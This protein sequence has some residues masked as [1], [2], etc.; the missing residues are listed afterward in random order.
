MVTRFVN[1][2]GEVLRVSP[3][4]PLPVVVQGGGPT[5]V[6]SSDITD[7]TDVGTALLTAESPAAA[8]TTLGAAPDTLQGVPSGGAAG[9]VLKRTGDGVAWQPDANT[10]YGP[11]TGTTTGL[12]KRGAPV[13]DATD[14]ADVVTQFNALLAALR[15]AGVIEE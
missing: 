14:E 5:P 13:A 11:A 6:S 8:R 10:T 4:S 12:V 15:T 3:S 7:A 2:E 1:E 9:Q